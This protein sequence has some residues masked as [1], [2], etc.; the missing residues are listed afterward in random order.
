VSVLLDTA[1]IIAAERGKFD[2]P[3]YL[4][5]IGHAPVALAAISASELLHG[6]ERASDAAVRQR[7]S[8]FVEGL[9][10]N[11]PVIPFGLAEARAHA[12]IWAELATAGTLVGTHDLQ[13][14]ATALVA[15][16]LVATLNV[17]D[18]RRVPGLRLAELEPFVRA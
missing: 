1:V 8:E 5:A 9:L 14:A 2:M 10:A 6:V 11:V 4:A 3:G 16:S 17:T 12:R 15:G 13:I 18:F 7:R